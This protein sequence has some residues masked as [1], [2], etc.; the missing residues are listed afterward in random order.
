VF[1]IGF[2]PFRGGPFRHVD[3]SGAAAIVQQL[4]RLDAAYPGRFTPCARLVQMAKEDG[5]FYPQKGKPV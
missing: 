5:R 1:G 4:Q 2:P 3:A